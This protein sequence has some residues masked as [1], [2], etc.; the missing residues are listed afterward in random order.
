MSKFYRIKNDEPTRDLFEKK[1]IYNLNAKSKTYQK[2]L[3]NFNFAE[4]ALYGR[5][6]RLYYPIITH[7]E[8]LPLKDIKTKDGQ[9]R[10]MALNFVVDAFEAMVRNMQ[11]KLLVNEI[12]KTEVFLSG[13]VAY[14]AYIHPKKAYSDYLNLFFRAFEQIVKDNKI[15]FKDFG[16]F[17]KLIMPYIKQGA[18]KKPFTLSGFMKSRY[19]PIECSGLVINVSNLDFV[20]DSMKVKKMYNS[21]NWDYFVNLCAAYGFMIDRNNPSRIV[22][23]IAAAEM[24]KF[25]EPYGVLTTDHI[26]NGAYKKAHLDYLPTFQSMLFKMY[27]KYKVRSYGG[28]GADGS[29]GDDSGTDSGRSWYGRGAGRTADRSDRSA[30]SLYGGMGV[31]AHGGD[32]GLGH[33][34]MRGGS[35]GGLY[36]GM[37]DMFG[38]APPGAMG[39]TY[40]RPGMLGDAPSGA[41]DEGISDGGLYGAMDPRAYGGDRG[42][43]LSMG[44]GISD[45][46]LY[47]G[48]G[49]DGDRGLGHRGMG[50]GISDGGLYGG[51]GGKGDRGLGHRGMGDGSDGGPGG[52]YAEIA[53]GRSKSVL[54]KPVYYTIE[55]LRSQYS[56][57]YFINLYCQVRFAEEESQFREDEKLRLIDNTIELSAQGI[58]KSLDSFELII[59]KTFDY[60]GSLSYNKMRLDKLRE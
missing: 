9:D 15:R 34:G 54:V 8:I 25:S 17:I 3:V 30:A 4:K 59:N 33:S 50:D 37:G 1:L 55:D 47:G 28:R 51:M 14:N 21:K 18:N 42:P 27:N 35:D 57:Q 48:M 13:I 46:A 52:V 41:M 22:A 19:C 5:V 11:K 7:G 20:D 29:G 49:G 44:E 39:R 16:E 32:R 58:N 53:P 2:H 38:D 10:K 26:L 31:D 6:D 36:G 43:V 60:R 40:D 23:D 45:G 12:S 24:L 56:D